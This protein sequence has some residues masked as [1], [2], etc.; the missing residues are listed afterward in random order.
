MQ[1]L[2]F[3]REGTRSPLGGQR[4]NISTRPPPLLGNHGF[5]FTVAPVN[6]DVVKLPFFLTYITELKLPRNITSK[7]KSVC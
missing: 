5:N 1:T 4:L 3:Q 7:I 2:T 6:C